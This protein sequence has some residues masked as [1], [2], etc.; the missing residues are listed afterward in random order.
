[1]SGFGKKSKGV[2]TSREQAGGEPLTVFRKQDTPTVNSQYVNGQGMDHY[3]SIDP[4]SRQAPVIFRH[5]PV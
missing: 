5:N 1:M 4:L 2:F 3:G